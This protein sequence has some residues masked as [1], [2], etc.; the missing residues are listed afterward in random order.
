MFAEVSLSFCTY[1]IKKSL[2]YNFTCDIDFIYILVCIFEAKEK[3]LIQFSMSGHT[4]FFLLFFFF[5]HP[6]FEDSRKIPSF[7]FFLAFI[8]SEILNSNCSLICLILLFQIFVSI[9]MRYLFL[10][11]HQSQCLK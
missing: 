10:L 2:Y 8:I 6:F 9:L 7:I 5:F 3:L 4:M 1:T 11:V